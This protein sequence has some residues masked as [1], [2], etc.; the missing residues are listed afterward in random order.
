MAQ[1]PNRMRSEMLDASSAAGICGICVESLFLTCVGFFLALDLIVGVEVE[2]EDEAG[3]GDSAAVDLGVASSRPQT[4]PPGGGGGGITQVETVT[5]FGTSSLVVRLSTILRQRVV[6]E[7]QQRN[8][9]TRSTSVVNTSNKDNESEETPSKSLPRWL[10]RNRCLLLRLL[11]LMS[12][13]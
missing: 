7:I 6:S 2:D 4:P 13:V 10:A 11:S 12:C 9:Q 3:K 1:M 5:D 8:L